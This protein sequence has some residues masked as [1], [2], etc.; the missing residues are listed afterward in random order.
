[1]ITAGLCAAHA[2]AVH[3]L[4]V[5]FIPRVLI[6]QMMQQQCCLQQG[7]KKQQQQNRH[8]KRR[9]RMNGSRFFLAKP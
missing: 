1:V 3:G 7:G 5:G 8:C 4:L 9:N 6:Q 2:E